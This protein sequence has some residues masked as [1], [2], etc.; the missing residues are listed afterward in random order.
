M[1]FF[2]S[3]L[4]W[5]ST[6][7][8]NCDAVTL[9]LMNPTDTSILSANGVNPRGDQTILSGTRGRD[10]QGEVDR[11]LLRFDLTSIPTNATIQSVILTLT[12]VQAP[13]Q[14]I[15]SNFQLFRMLTA[16]DETATWNQ[17]RALV[18]WAAPGGKEG[19]DYLATVSAS[20]E[21]DDLDS[22]DFGP[23]DQLKADLQKWVANPTSNQGWLLMSD[24]EGAFFTARHF[25]SSES[26]D[27]P[28]LAID[29]SLPAAGGPTLTD[30]QAKTNQFTFSFAPVS[31]QAYAV[32]AR[33]NLTQGNWTV[34]TNIPARTGTNAIIVTNGISGHSEFFRVKAQ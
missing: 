4:I 24:S 34:V 3:A 25:G 13:Q 30:S 32:E 15:P 8:L 17:P 18:P 20:V 29:Y 28:Q 33:T 10:A 19:V 7:V 22:Y 21:I 11:G 1:L 2:L 16:W 14:P 6:A 23:S 9:I 26:S 12:V 5:L 31:G 27:P